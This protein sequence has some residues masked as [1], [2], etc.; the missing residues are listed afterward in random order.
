MTVEYRDIMTDQM[1]KIVTYEV[2]DFHML[3]HMYS[4]YTWQSHGFTQQND[5]TQV[6]MKFPV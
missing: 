3:E 2:T 5:V 4:W 6:I 1:F